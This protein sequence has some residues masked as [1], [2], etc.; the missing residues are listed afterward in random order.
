MWYQFFLMILPLIFSMM[1]HCIFLYKNEMKIT[2]M[3]NINNSRHN[4]L[5]KW[6]SRKRKLLGNTAETWTLGC[7]LHSVTLSHPKRWSYILILKSQFST[8]RQIIR[9]GENQ[10]IDTFFNQKNQLPWI[11]DLNYSSRSLI[12]FFPQN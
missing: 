1:Q 6:K 4:F 5:N 10:Q 2:K 7:T 8:C 3:E 9:N 11:I 12:F